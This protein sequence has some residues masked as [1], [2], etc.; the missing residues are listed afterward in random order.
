[1]EKKHGEYQYLEL[2]RDLI[3]TG[4]KKEDRT[5]VGTVGKFGAMMRFSLRDVCQKMLLC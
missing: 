3:E 2:I 4:T 1:M 5:G